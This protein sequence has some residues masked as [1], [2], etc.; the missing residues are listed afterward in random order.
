MSMS[1]NMMSLL[2]CY[3]TRINGILLELGCRNIDILLMLE[4]RVGW[5]S[6][7][8][9]GIDRIRDKLVAKLGIEDT[10]GKMD[11]MDTD[12][13][14]EI[15]EE[16]ANSM[17]Y[18]GVKKVEVKVYAQEQ[19][20]VLELVCTLEQVMAQVKEQEEVLSQEQESKVCVES[21][22]V[23]GQA[24]G[25]LQA[26]AHEEQVKASHEDLALVMVKAEEVHK[27]EELAN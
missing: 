4:L 26:L 6:S 1:M 8:K 24:S 21:H 19:V 27:E 22:E 3:T 15:I 5:D 17:G 20:L 2:E 11:K 23:S 12:Y 18:H 16:K 25:E 7:G 14:R 13:I 10:E 9:M